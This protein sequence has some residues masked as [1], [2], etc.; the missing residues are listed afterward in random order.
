MAYKWFA[1]NRRNVPGHLV[2]VFRYLASASVISIT[3]ICSK[4]EARLTPA[5][6][7]ED[8]VAPCWPPQRWGAA[9]GFGRFAET[10]YLLPPP[11]LLFAQRNQIA[12][13]GWKRGFDVLILFNT[14]PRLDVPSINVGDV[15]SL[16]VWGLLQL[17]F[18]LAK[19]GKFIEGHSTS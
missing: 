19:V 5:N 3:S 18:Q 8:S 6:K 14:F 15:F 7:P 2:T 4:S 10:Y 1:S 11:L 17:L 9:H 12:H 13:W 16:T